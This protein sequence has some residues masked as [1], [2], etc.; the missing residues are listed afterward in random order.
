MDAALP[1]RAILETGSVWALRST[2]YLPSEAQFIAGKCPSPYFS[3][4]IFLHLKIR[5]NRFVSIQFAFASLVE[6]MKMFAC[7]TTINCHFQ[8]RILHLKPD[9]I[10]YNPNDREM[11]CILRR[12]GRFESPYR[13]ENEPRVETRSD[14]EIAPAA[15]AD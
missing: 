6:E 4:L 7:M 15:G 10:P 14:G 12:S 11:C 9:L 13:A 2:I 5:L 1:W 3:F 8:T